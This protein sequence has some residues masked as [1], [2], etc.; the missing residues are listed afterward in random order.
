M[1]LLSGSKF[2]TEFGKIGTDTL[3][4]PGWIENGNFN[5]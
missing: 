5:K 4:E 2:L 3:C 1:S